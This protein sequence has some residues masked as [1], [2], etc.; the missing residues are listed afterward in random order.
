VLDEGYAPL[1]A[2]RATVARQQWKRAILK[3]RPLKGLRITVTGV[4]K[5]GIRSE[6]L[7]WLRSLGAHPEYDVTGKTD[8]LI[9]GPHYKGDDRNKIKKAKQIGVKMMTEGQFYRRYID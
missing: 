3:K 6:V 8:L 1:E 9:R 4:L 2:R 7:S 5:Q